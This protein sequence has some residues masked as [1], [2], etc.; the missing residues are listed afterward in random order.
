[1]QSEMLSPTYFPFTFISPTLVEVVSLF[2]QRVVVYQPAY[3]KPDHALQSWIDS[4]LLDVRSPS[5]KMLDKKRVEAALRDLKSWG[6]LHQ[7]ADLAL[8]KLLRDAIQPVTPETPMIASAIRSKEGASSE[9]AGEPHLSIQ[10]FLHLAHEFDREAWELDEQLKLVDDEYQALQSSFRQDQEETTLTTG[11]MN[12]SVSR[13]GETFR[14]LMIKKRLVAWNH[15]FQNDPSGSSV[16]FTD[17]EPAI[18]HLLDGI[19]E[20]VDVLDLHMP[21]R[22]ADSGDEQD[23]DFVSNLFSEIFHEILGTPWNSA[24]EEKVIRTSQ[25]F[26]AQ[27][28]ARERTATSTRKGT[29][30]MRWYV[31]PGLAGHSLLNRRCLQTAAHGE[32]QVDGV[33]NTLLGLMRFKF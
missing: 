31:V 21:C 3:A 30:S 11:A 24:L 1:M 14:D 5:E 25:E 17:S 29:M 13:G 7:K 4:G 6:S 15:L 19:D 9:Q 27:A 8:L 16:L 20:K 28:D 2:F 33:Q 18:D 12:E 26:A 22:A 23:T 32:H 10:L